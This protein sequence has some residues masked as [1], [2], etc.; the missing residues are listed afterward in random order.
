ME[1]INKKITAFDVFMM[2][3]KQEHLTWTFDER[4][5]YLRVLRNAKDI[6]DK[7]LLDLK[8]DEWQERSNYNEN[9]DRNENDF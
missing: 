3:D 9:Y 7:L 8:D 2:I 1:T 4:E 6:V 5:K